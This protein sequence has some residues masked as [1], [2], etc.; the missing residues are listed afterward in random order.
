M[1]K[2]FRI[3]CCALTFMLVFACI[4][5]SVLAANQ[6]GSDSI[7]KVPLLVII[8][9]FDANGNGINDY[10]QSNPT[11]LYS[12]K[13]KD[14]Y[15]E[16]W[17]Q[18]TP[19]D[20]W[21]RYFG[22]HNSVAAYYTEMTMGKMTFVPAEF[23]K[24]VPNQK[25]QNGVLAV[26]VNIAHPTA[27][28]D[29]HAAIRTIITAADE[30]INFAAY[31][32]NG[33]R[34]CT[35]DELAI[36]I[37]N[38]GPDRSSTGQ[39]THSGSPKSYF[40]VHGTSQPVSMQLDDV[41]ITSN[42]M[43]GR[44]CNLGE[45]S[46]VGTIMP[47]GVPVHE[48]AHNFGAEDLYNRGGGNDA[49][50]PQ[51]YRFSLQCSGNHSGGGATPTYLDP[52]QRVK[53]GWAEEEV[54]TDGTYT[55][56]ST[57]TG[58]YKVLRVNTPDPDEYF[59]IEVRL[60]EGFER[61]LT[62]G[63]TGGIMV[64]HIDE[65]INRLY[66]ASGE[67]DSCTPVN[68]KSHDPGIVPLLREGYDKY[69]KKMTTQTPDDPYYYVSDD[70]ATAVCNTINY[71]SVTGNSPS[72]NSYPSNWEG[73][74]NF[75][76][77]IEALSEPGQEMKVKITTETSGKAAPT[78]IT[79]TQSQATDS[80][81]LKNT[82]LAIKGE[83]LT[84]YGVIYSKDDNPTLENGKY[85]EGVLSADGTYFTTTLTGL[86]AGTRYYYKVVTANENMEGESAVISV[87]SA[88]QATE[89]TYFELKLHK[90][91]TNKDKVNTVKVDFG[92]KIGDAL[93]TTYM[94]K[95]GYTFCGWYLDAAFTQPYDPDFTMTKYGELEL[96]AKW[97]EGTSS[98]TTT[99]KKD[100]PPEMTS[101]SE[102][103]DK[104]STDGS[105]NVVTT[106]T[107]V[108]DGITTTDG[109]SESKGCGST[110][111]AGAAIAIVSVIG[112]GLVLGKKKTK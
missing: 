11:K 25:V 85:A 94:E 43:G 72:L 96:F 59:L 42:G 51:P 104:P 19:D 33:D 16:Q 23:T 21:D 8:A 34:R 97:E 32:T 109:S 89:K 80:I 64:W 60:K 9:S 88:S 78:I 70:P 93:A 30:Y 92:K 45:Y 102:S 74:H 65:G 40:G 95:A 91:L 47:I 22:E 99:T 44:V 48:L 6:K 46:K 7:K 36:L 71:L 79:T 14:Y 69:G 4:A 101:G 111:G 106:V 103:T 12:D 68:G 98:T 110:I 62:K 28:G 112:T 105:G 1:K 35:Q 10:D 58:K 67:A 24:T 2:F 18:T 66:F 15:G 38:A 39:Y 56:Y 76:L 107:T 84:K 77:K 54:V 13:T 5:P 90:Y 81:V 55:L 31:D 100:N 87:F 49:T 50:W 57:L 3:V 82:I 41:F 83:K 52:Y 86:D 17:A 61:N 37:L 108:P 26:T 63:G 29:A 75:N 53:I 27:K 20:H 73:A